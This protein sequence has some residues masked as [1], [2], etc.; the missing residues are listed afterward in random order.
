MLMADLFDCLFQV[1]CFSVGGDLIGCGVC[2]LWSCVSP[3]LVTHK[4]VAK[5]IGKLLLTEFGEF[6]SFCE[7]HADDIDDDIYDDYDID[8]DN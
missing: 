5:E 8:N 4:L 7:N 6:K 1:A 3:H 2:Q